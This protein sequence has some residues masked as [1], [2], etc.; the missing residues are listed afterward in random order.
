VTSAAKRRILSREWLSY[1]ESTELAEPVTAKQIRQSR[2][3]FYAGA[4]SLFTRIAIE[5]DSLPSREVQRVLSSIGEELS[6]FQTDLCKKRNVPI[7]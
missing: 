6:V 3:A 5:C 4:L 1:I 2:E 7:H